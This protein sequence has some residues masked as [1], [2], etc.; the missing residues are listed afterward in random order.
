MLWR[1]RQAVEYHPASSSRSTRDRLDQGR[2]G[3]A[4]GRT[5]RGSRWWHGIA[6]RESPVLFEAGLRAHEWISNSRHGTFPCTAHSGVNAVSATR[7]PLR[8]QRRLRHSQHECSPASRLTSRP[9]VA[10]ARH[11]ERRL[12]YRP[13]APPRKRRGPASRWVLR[14]NPPRPAPAIHAH[15]HDVHSLNYGFTPGWAGP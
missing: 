13:C 14:H 8:G 5:R 9:A 6:Q 10:S 15:Q 12:L 7:L 4:R 2:S 11:L 3:K 1:E